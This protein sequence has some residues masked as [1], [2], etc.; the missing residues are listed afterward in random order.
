MNAVFQDEL[1]VSRPVSASLPFRVRLAR[2]TDELGR[3]VDVRFRAYSRHLPEFAESL[4][5]PE[6]LD[7]LP[8][9]YV[10]LAESKLDGSPV[11]SLRLQLNQFSPLAIESSVLLPAALRKVNLAEITRLAS[12]EGRNGKLVS[13]VLIKAAYLLCSALQ[14]DHAIIT[15][16]RP[17]DQRYLQLDFADVFPDGAFV[18][19]EHIGGVP[20]RV[21]GFEIRSGERRWFERSHTLYSFMV[22]TFHADIEVFAAL[23]PDW[24]SSQIA[25]VSADRAR[26]P[27]QSVASSSC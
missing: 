21:L 26:L 11:G 18:P 1:G 13:T 8:G 10:L 14:V 20:H 27:L 15:A 17:L 4:R 22:G 9:T 16:R 19:M 12:E 2:N 23:A 25:T 24:S 7:T 3:A 5:H 6:P